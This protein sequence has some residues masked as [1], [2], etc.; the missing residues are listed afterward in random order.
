VPVLAPVL[1]WL[2][3]LVFIWMIV[4]AGRLFT[5]D[6]GPPDARGLGIGLSIWGTLGAESVGVS[7]C[8][9]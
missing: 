1:Q 8:R 9:A 5:R 7:N 3:V 6:A 2:P 4:G